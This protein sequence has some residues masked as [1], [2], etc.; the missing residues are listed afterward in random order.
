VTARLLTFSA[1]LILVFLFTA[2]TSAQQQPQNVIFLIGDGMGTAQVTALKLS[3]H[4]TNFDRFAL[5]GFSITRSTN[6]LVTESSAGG[7]ALACG[8]RTYNGGVGVD[9]LGRPVESVLERA[10]KHGK[11]AGVVVTSSI[12]HATPACFLAHVNHRKKELEIAEQIAVS[13][14]D[15]LIGGGRR[16]FDQHDGTAP[17]R[18]LDSMRMRGYSVLSSMPCD[19]ATGSH[20]I[21][22]LGDEGLPPAGTRTYKLSDMVRCALD[23]LGNN[24]KGFF[25]MVEG[26]QIDW[27]CSYNDFSQLLCEMEDFDGAVGVCLDYAGSHP[28]TLV[29]VTAD[30]E[31]AG[32][33]IQG[34]DPGGSD[35][36]ALWPSKDHSAAMVPV[37]AKGPGAEFF[38]GIQDNF[39]IG[40]KIKR[41]LG[42]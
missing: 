37:F 42:D 7:T 31:T 18:L 23:R 6:N 11:S 14:V 36:K 39:E 34:K 12:T 28:N 15:V 4:V 22:L 17:K 16:F 24:E 25:L 20:L 40:L 21:A 29:L 2:S 13:G 8:L 1:T 3:K 27:A 30:H 5:S 32:L 35:M 38:G 9:T 33:M 19:T 26:S 10:R 41:L